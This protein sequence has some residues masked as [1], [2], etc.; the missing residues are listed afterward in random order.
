M[1]LTL[2]SHPGRTN[3]QTAAEGRQLYGWGCALLV[4]ALLAGCATPVPPPAQAPA[5][6]VIAVPPPAPAPAPAPA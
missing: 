1:A 3:R 2:D 6:A 4:A 5:P